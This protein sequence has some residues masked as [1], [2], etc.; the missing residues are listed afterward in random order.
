MNKSHFPSKSLTC[1]YTTKMLLELTADWA[2]L[3]RLLGMCQEKQK[4]K[5]TKPPKNNQA[6]KQ[7]E[8]L[9]AK[10][11]L[12]FESTVFKSLK[13]DATMRWE[14]NQSNTFSELIANF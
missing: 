13:Y 2:K 6:K 3:N 14:K 8:A 10:G 9:F 5:Q 4:N 12:P 11:L 1:C 7:T